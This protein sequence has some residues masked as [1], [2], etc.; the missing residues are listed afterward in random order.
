M[1]DSDAPQVLEAERD[2]AGRFVTGNA[3]GP[4]RPRRAVELTYLRA[5]SDELT[6][7]AWREI[8]R[9]AVEDA[10][11]GDAKA[12]EWVTRYA[13]GPE[14]VGL[15]ALAVRD[16][17]ALDDSLEVRGLARVE[18]TPDILK[19]QAPD[20]PIAAALAVLEAERAQAERERQA[21]ERARKAAE[22]KVRQAQ[23]EQAGQAESEGPGESA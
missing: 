4:G 6:L 19:W 11:A 15:M 1:S 3:G 12:R 23:R 18:T 5:L 9:R 17:L 22:R 8:V 16:E 7:E 20:T 2:S 21:D 10:R 14:P 13:L